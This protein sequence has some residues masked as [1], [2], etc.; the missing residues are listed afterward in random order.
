MDPI[1]EKLL[2]LGPPF[3]LA[4]AVHES[5]HAYTANHFGD[6]TA[7]KLGRITLN[8]IPHIDFMGAIV[9]LYAGFGWAKP[10]PVNYANLKNPRKDGL[11]ISL[12]GPV[13]NL[14]LA[15]R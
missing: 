8:P 12:A 2:Y 15:I 9:L 13:S 14:I 5:A 11:W 6:P 3:L 10:V 4:I 1:V 7:K